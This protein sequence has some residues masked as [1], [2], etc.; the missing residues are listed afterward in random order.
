MRV[1]LCVRQYVFT[2]LDMFRQK[3]MG[4]RFAEDVASIFSLTLGCKKRGKR[5]GGVLIA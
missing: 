5:P 4:L 3:Q 1:M 2:P